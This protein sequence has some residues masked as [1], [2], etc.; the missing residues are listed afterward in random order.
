MQLSQAER[1]VEHLR[2]DLVR[3]QADAESVRGDV[4]RILSA[5]KRRK[6]A[7]GDLLKHNLLHEEKPK[8]IIIDETIDAWWRDFRAYW[9]EVPSE[10]DEDCD[11]DEDEDKGDANSGDNEY[12]EEEEE[13]VK[14]G[15]DNIDVSV[16]S[17]SIEGKDDDDEPE[18]EFDPSRKGS[19]LDQTFLETA[20][21]LFER[22]DE[23]PKK[24]DRFKVRFVA[25][26]SDY[27]IQPEEWHL[28]DDGDLLFGLIAD[29][30][31][32]DDDELTIANLKNILTGGCDEVDSGVEEDTCI[33]V[34][35]PDS[36]VYY[37]LL[38]EYF[39]IRWKYRIVDIPMIEA[40]E[41]D[42]D[43]EDYEDDE[44]KDN[45]DEE[46]DEGGEGGECA[47]DD[48]KD[49]EDDTRDNHDGASSDIALGLILG[50]AFEQWKSGQ[51]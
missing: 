23:L 20:N 48:D 24:C 4:A 49:E 7:L 35:D 16:V 5:L 25:A 28:D 19:D 8:G 15:E 30:N 6:Q 41:A 2:S 46:D 29:G 27:W 37:R 12:G 51:R 47:D 17:G 14:D 43:D 26:N 13:D 22:L 32:H 42:D 38:D 18:H 31:N 50:H 9:D 45:E 44:V 3:V 36:E 40:D 1:E 34:N 21:D 33:Y 39:H 10:D 11:D